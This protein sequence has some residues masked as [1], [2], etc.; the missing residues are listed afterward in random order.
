MF[1]LAIIDDLLFKDP[2]LTS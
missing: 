2:N 1:Q